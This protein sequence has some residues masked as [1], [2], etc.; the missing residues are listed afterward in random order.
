MFPVRQQ[1][2]QK[3]NHMYKEELKVRY[4]SKKTR[5][6]INLFTELELF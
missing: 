5:F 1:A 4:I 3:S 6:R 2:D